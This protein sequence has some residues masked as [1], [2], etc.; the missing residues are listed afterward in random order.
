MDT[1]P[2]QREQSLLLKRIVS[3]TNAK[4][5]KQ[6]MLRPNSP[7]PNIGL[8]MDIVYEE[9]SSASEAPSN[10]SSEE[11]SLNVAGVEAVALRDEVQ[12]YTWDMDLD[13]LGQEILS[14]AQEDN[15]SVEWFANNSGWEADICV[16]SN[17]SGAHDSIPPGS[18]AVPHD[19]E[20]TSTPTPNAST[21]QKTI[22]KSALPQEGMLLEAIASSRSMT[23]WT[24]SDYST[25][26]QSL[27]ANKVVEEY[28]TLP[29]YPKESNRSGAIEDELFMH[30]LDEVF[31]IQYPFYNSSDKQLRLWIF[32]NL[33]RV[34]SVYYATLA[35]SKQHM[36]STMKSSL[37]PTQSNETNYYDMA[38]QEMDLGLREFSGLS[39]TARLAR[40]VEGIT[41][42]LQILFCDVRRPFCISS[43]KR[44]NLSA[45]YSCLLAAQGIGGRIFTE[46]LP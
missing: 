31:Y 22:G 39:E 35:L 17:L 2:L 12:F 11:H 21:A 45:G 38:L 41:C 33:R 37:L 3:Q 36:Q 10:S 32:S 18:S 40:S 5:R 30:Y 14:E 20:A 28:V 4:K 34:R 15:F 44:A 16:D 9:T 46:Q 13:L 42:T 6:R 29:T 7:V 23:Q 24:L 27:G 1:G 43:Q 8:D 26:A 25:P 19:S